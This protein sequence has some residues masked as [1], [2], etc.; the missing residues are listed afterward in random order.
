MHPASSGVRISVCTPTPPKEQS[1]KIRTTAA[2]R[3]LS[4]LIALPAFAQQAPTL[5]KRLGGYDAIVALTTTSSAAWRAIRSSPASSAATAPSR[6]RACASKSW[7]NS[8]RPGTSALAKVRERPL[9]GIQAARASPRQRLNSR[10]RRSPRPITAAISPM[11]S[12]NALV[13]LASSKGW[14]NVC[15]PGERL[16]LPTCSS[17]AR[18]QSR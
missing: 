1:T 16:A 15:S 17:Q 12:L 2:V 11:R 8:A 14:S 10:Y 9:P 6:S 13:A 7:T 5:Q 3:A 4:L 18:G